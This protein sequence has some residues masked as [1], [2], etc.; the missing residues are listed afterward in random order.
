MIVFNPIVIASGIAV[1]FGG[2]TAPQGWLLCDGSAISRA[3]FASLF[4]VISTAY[5]VG[6]GSTTFNLPDLRQ[7][8]PLGKAVSGTG[9]T[10]GGSGGTIDHLHTAD[11]PITTTST[12]SGTVAALAVTGIAAST[13]HTHTVDIPSFNTGTA[14]PPFQTVNYIIKI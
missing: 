6:D 7:R 2:T 9:S 11:P 1:P 13:G 10:L 12:P 5:G 4:N 8:F 3:T 14:N